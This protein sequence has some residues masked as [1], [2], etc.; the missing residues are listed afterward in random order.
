MSKI[1]YDIEMF[2]EFTLRSCFYESYLPAFSYYDG[3][4][5]YFLLNTLEVFRYEDGKFQILS[6]SFERREEMEEKFGLASDMHMDRVENVLEYIVNA[7]DQNKMVICRTLNSWAYDEKSNR[8]TEVSNGIY[9]WNLIFGYDSEKKLFDVTEHYT[10]AAALYYPMKMKYDVLEKSYYDSFKNP[11]FEQSL[12]VLWKEK[13]VCALNDRE[14]YLY[15]IQKREK[16]FIHAKDSII[17]Y[18]NDIVHNNEKKISYTDIIQLSE[19]VKVCQVLNYIIQKFQEQNDIGTEV[20]NQTNLLR[21]Y[22]IKWMHQP[23]DKNWDG[24]KKYTYSVTELL[25]HIIIGR[26]TI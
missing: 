6:D 3:N 26:Q 11:Q 17:R 20:I 2:H 18:I 10:N 4:I 5:L 8:K 9:H 13:K 21:T 25:D 7:L 23:V 24:I 12:D 16:E 14:S 15:M 19:V 22:Y 1:K